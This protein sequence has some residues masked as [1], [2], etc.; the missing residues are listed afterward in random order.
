MSYEALIEDLVAAQMDIFGREAVEMARQVDGLEVADDGTVERVAGDGVSIADAL[1]SVYV[2][3][4]GGAATVTLRSAAEAH[5]DRVTLP[6]A[7]Q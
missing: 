7:L 4:L 6:A 2:E 5:A 1:V 3:D